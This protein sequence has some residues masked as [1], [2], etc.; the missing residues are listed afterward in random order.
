VCTC[1]V[2]CLGVVCVCGCVCVCVHFYMILQLHKFW[3]SQYKNI[4]VCISS[5]TRPNNEAFI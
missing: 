2:V 3:C 1:F 5:M 4:I